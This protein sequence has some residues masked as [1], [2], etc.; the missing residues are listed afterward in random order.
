M[1]IAVDLGCKAM[2][3][4]NK[5]TNK[6]LVFWFCNLAGLDRERTLNSMSVKIV[7]KKAWCQYCSKG[8]LNRSQLSRHMVVHTGERPWKCGRCGKTFQ[9]K[10]HLTGHYGRVH[11]DTTN[12]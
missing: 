9:Q 12:I 6:Y 7:V 3:Q 10:A 1:N 2:K 11:L 5:Q 4:T 8:F